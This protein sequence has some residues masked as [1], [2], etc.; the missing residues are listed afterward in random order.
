MNHLQIAASQWASSTM[1]SLDQT[2][3]LS[4]GY[5]IKE[6]KELLL[7][8][9]NMLIETFIANHKNDPGLVD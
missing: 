3:Y 7:K 6:T 4:C 8:R 2:M 5:Y 1:R 9:F